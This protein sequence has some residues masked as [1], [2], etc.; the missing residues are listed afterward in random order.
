M[1]KALKII[2][3]FSVILLIVFISIK[4]D[5]NKR[6]ELIKVIIEQENNMPEQIEKIKEIQKQINQKPIVNAGDDRNIT[7]GEEVRLAV[8]AKDSDG[9]IVSYLWKE[10]NKTLSQEESFDYKFDRGIH[11]LKVTVTDNKGVEAE[12]NITINVGYWMLVKVEV[13]GESTVYEYNADKKIIKKLV[14]SNQ[15]GK[16]DTI[17]HYDDKGR[18]VLNAKYSNGRGWD[19]NIT[20]QFTDDG[21]LKEHNTILHTHGVVDI[22]KKIIYNEKGNILKK[23]E[24]RYL[25]GTNKYEKTYYYSDTDKLLEIIGMIKGKMFMNTKYQYNNERLVSE[26]ISYD[27]ID[28]NYKV[29]DGKDYIYEDEV[30]KEVH[31]KYYKDYYNYR[32]FYNEKGLVIENL[33]DMARTKYFYNED[34]EKIKEEYYIKDSDGEFEQI[35]YTLF[36]EEQTQK[37]SLNSDKVEITYKYIP[38][39]DVAIEERRDVYDKHGN[40]I[41]IWDDVANELIEK[42]FYRFMI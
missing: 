18:E 9:E 5:S 31:Y 21:K 14:D 1:K 39:K 37:I 33:D 34:G 30:L 20:K 41:E 2:F 29:T 12:D 15:D 8:S 7:F 42:R 17:Y 24:I 25:N 38:L 3:Y 11:H 10:G 6:D 27:D 28:S 16:A 13:G 36:D 22:F 26:R 32:E 19:K 4:E 23:I 35:S 40:L